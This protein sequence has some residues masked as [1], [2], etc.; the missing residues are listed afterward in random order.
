MDGSM[1]RH[2]FLAASALAGACVVADGLLQRPGS[3]RQ[4]SGHPAAFCP[5]QAITARL[6]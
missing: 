3:A 5:H 2:T 4:S 6:A 1:I